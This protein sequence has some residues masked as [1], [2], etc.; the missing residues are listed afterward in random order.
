[1]HIIIFV[2]ASSPQQSYIFTEQFIARSRI[3]SSFILDHFDLLC[4]I[5]VFL[6]LP[7]IEN[8][9]KTSGEQEIN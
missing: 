7:V 9:G 4:I 1:M 6:M 2:F 5:R 8:R 3:H